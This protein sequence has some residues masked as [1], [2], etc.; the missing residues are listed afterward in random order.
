M[1]VAENQKIELKSGVYTAV[2]LLGKGKSGYSWLVKSPRGSAVLKLIHDEPCAYYSFGDKL[3]AELRAYDALSPLMPLPRLLESDGNEKYLLKDFVPGQ[4]LTELI[5][6][7]T[8]PESAFRQMF[9]LCAK[10][11]PAGLNI[12]YFPANF[13]WNGGELVYIDY[14][15]NPYCDEWNFENWG[16][17]YW[18][19][20]AGMHK[21]LATGD[22]LAIN[23]AKDSGK[24]IVEP[25]RAAAEALAAKYAGCA[26]AV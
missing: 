20:S 5:A 22:P 15:C 8:L 7:K 4:P 9:A 12:D 3:G 11:Y 6:A 18:L 14:E 17:Y 26:G 10:L 13:I 24:P 25:F 23:L 21:F 16:I 2:R 19:N 1:Q